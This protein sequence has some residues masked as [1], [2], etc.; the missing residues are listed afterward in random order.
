MFSRLSF[1]DKCQQIF[2]S[3]L[4]S[5]IGGWGTLE[6]HLTG[7]FGVTFAMLSICENI[8]CKNTFEVYSRYIWELEMEHSPLCILSS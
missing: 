7:P 2:L 3:R 5:S 8:S 4:C 1:S 6:R